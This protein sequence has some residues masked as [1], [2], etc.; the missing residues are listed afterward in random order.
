MRTKADKGGLTAAQERALRALLVT[1]NH[2][3]AARQA[4]L[5]SRTLRRYLNLPAFRE[6]Y[7]NRRRDLMTSAIC[8]AQRAATDMVEV[9]I[10]VATDEEA[11]ASARITAANSVY[12]IGADGLRM[13]DLET[14][15][16]ALE[17]LLDENLTGI[18]IKG[19]ANGAGGRR[20]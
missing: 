9:L 7:L 17:E 4:G 15:I 19:R 14:R 3:E 12:G 11:P 13:E 5:T 20:R 1:S 8:R 16:S 10:S 18:G 2:E 6:E